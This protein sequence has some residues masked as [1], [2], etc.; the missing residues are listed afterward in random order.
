MRLAISVD[1]QE[2]QVIDYRT[3]D[4][5]ETWKQNVLCNSASSTITHSFKEP[6]NHTLAITA[7]DPG[8]IVDR[9]TIDFGGLKSGYSAV[10]E[11][12]IMD[13]NEK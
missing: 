11:T 4:R 8:I 3:F 7:L 6:G 12:K 5:S 10:P 13:G 1:G 9:I 2:P